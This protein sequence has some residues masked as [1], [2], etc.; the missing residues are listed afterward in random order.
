M[1]FRPPT[2]YLRR[3][4]GWV[5]HVG[6]VLHRLAPG[7]AFLPSRTFRCHVFRNVDFQRIS[8]R[9]ET[10]YFAMT[11]LQ[12]LRFA[13]WAKIDGF[14]NNQALAATHNVAAST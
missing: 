3:H 1:T 2:S 6:W 9:N 4:V 10:A 8:A 11:L 12:A 13:N 14:P 5:P 7:H